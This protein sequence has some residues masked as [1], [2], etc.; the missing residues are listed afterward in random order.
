MTES[1]Y[2]SSNVANVAIYTSFYG[3]YALP[4]TQQSVK[5]LK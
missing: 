1:F 5:A 2:L 4:V 3:L